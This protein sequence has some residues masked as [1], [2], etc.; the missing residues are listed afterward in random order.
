MHAQWTYVINRHTEPGDLDS[1]AYTRVIYNG[2]TNRHLF[3]T[4]IDLSYWK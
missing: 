4:R 3:E 1:I 2:H